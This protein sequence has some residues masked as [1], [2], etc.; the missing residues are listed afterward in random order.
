MAHIQDEIDV[1]NGFCLAHSRKGSIVKETISIAGKDLVHSRRI[2]GKDKFEIAD[3]FAAWWGSYLRSP[4]EEPNLEH[5]PV[6]F[7]DLYSSVGGLS[8][9]AME[10]IRTM[11]MRPVSL[12][13]ADVDEDALRVYRSNIRPRE[14]VNDSVR[15][16]IDFRVSGKGP[17]A[18][19]AY[20]PTIK[21]PRL[22]AFKSRTDLILAGPPCQ[23]HSTLNNHSR[24]ND[25]KNLLYLTVPAIAVALDATHVVIENVPNVVN[26][27][28][29]VVEST[30]YLLRN[31]GYRISSAVLAADRL[32]WPQTRK[33]YFLVA[34]RGSAPLDLGALSAQLNREPLPVGWALNDF[35]ERD[36]NPE[37]VMFSVPKLSAENEF[38]VNYLFEKGVFNLPNEIRPDCHKQGTTYGAVYGRMYWDRPAPT[39][40]G[41]FL[42]PGRGRFVHPVNPRVLTPSEAARVQGFPS[43]FSFTPDGQKS[44]SRSDLAKWIGDAVPPILG[45]AA[46]LAAL[47]GAVGTEASEDQ[48]GE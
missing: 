20:E 14:I 41:G 18:K 1:L 27:Q 10:A 46:V 3:P 43:W 8:L 17:A 9:G 36:L 24:G 23:G 21:H 19:F 34:S 12:L 30:H 38:R 16:M 32:G 48:A 26:D 11:G 39:I 22:A 7:L 42:S 44:P 25:P 45:Y 28:S 15:A 35:L 5:K 13:A 31:A 33:R 40:T 6:R 47:G 4:R 37:D 29:A 2:H